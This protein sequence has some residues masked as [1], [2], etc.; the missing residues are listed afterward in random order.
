MDTADLLHFSRRARDSAEGFD[1][2]WRVYGAAVQKV[3]RADEAVVEELAQAH[4][5]EELDAGHAP[6][7]VDRERYRRN[8]SARETRRCGTLR[9][10]ESHQYRATPAIR[11]Q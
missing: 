8:G 2:D 10:P 3:G 5:R 6:A 7:T 1:H 4:R 11:S 9:S